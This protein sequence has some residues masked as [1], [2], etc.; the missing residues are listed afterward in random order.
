MILHYQNDWLWNYGSG[1]LFLSMRLNPARIKTA[2]DL[3]ALIREVK[4][5]VKQQDDSVPFEYS[6][7]DK[8]FEG[9][10]RSEWKMGTIL[11]IFTVMALVIACLGLFGL[12]A[13]SAEQRTKELGIR[14]VMGATVLELVITFSSE[15]T[16]LILI[17]VLIATPI[18]YFLVNQWLGNFAYRT[19]I[20]VMVFFT[21]I[22][23]ALIIAIL[24]ISYQSIS[25]AL[26]N[27]AKTLRSD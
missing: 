3:Q 24:T 10:F 5:V 8:E 16:R 27:P 17:A 1:P 6:F 20:E 4:E 11:K 18:S 22:V 2:G 7:M 9:S 19:P 23:G 26:T 12:A 15:F 13:F 21:A 25:A 14:K